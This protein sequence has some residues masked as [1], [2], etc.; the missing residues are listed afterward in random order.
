MSAVPPK[1]RQ[2]PVSPRPLARLL[3][4]LKPYRSRLAGAFVCLI[5]AASAALAFP[6]VLR[7]LLDSAFVVGDRGAL[8]RWALI[9]VGVFAVQ[10]VMNFVQVFLLSSTTEREIGRAH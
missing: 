8:D 3:P 6:A 2:R 7:V 10:G 4:L 9:L 5:V 1:A